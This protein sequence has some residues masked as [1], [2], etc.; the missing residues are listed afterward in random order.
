MEKKL[1]LKKALLPAVDVHG[2]TGL[3]NDPSEVDGGRVRREAPGSAPKSDG[4][5]DGRRHMRES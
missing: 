4:W 1:D 3:K 2:E 5:R